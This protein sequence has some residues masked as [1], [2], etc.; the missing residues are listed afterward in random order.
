VAKVLKVLHLSDQDGVTQVQVGGG[1]IESDLDDE[2][3]AEDEAC[4]EVVEADHI[5]TA[6]HESGN[7]VFDAYRHD[8]IY[9][10]WAEDSGRAVVGEQSQRQK[11]VLLT[12]RIGI[13][14]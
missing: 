8:A 2:R 10:D 3:A 5:Y 9:R 12:T 1:G 4:A 14:A 7:L 13:H 6:L 11:S